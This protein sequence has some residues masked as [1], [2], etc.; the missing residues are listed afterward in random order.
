MAIFQKDEFLGVEPFGR[1]AGP[2]GQG[3]VMG[4]G[5]EEGIVAHMGDFQ[6]RRVI[7]QGNQGRVQQ[8]RLKIGYESVREVLAQKEPQLWKARLEPG[9]RRRQ[10]KRGD[11][12]N[13]AQAKTALKRLGRALAGLDEILGGGKDGPGAG[14][15]LGPHGCQDDSGAAPV[16]DGR[17]ENAL[18]L[19]HARRKGGLGD[20]RGLRRAAER[21]VLGQKAQI[22]KLSQGGQHG[23]VT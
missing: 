22:L 20:M 14:Q 2:L 10:Q 15:G 18:Q 1:H 5:G 7:G 8:P 21:A 4:K 13:D 11:R 12:G 23:G 3:V 19:L 6:A 16:H 17:A 9:K